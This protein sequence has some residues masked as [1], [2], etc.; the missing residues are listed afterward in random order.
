MLKANQIEVIDEAISRGLKSGGLSL[1]LGFGKTRAS[2]CLGLR[3]DMG[4]I[5]VIVSKTLMASWIQEIEKAFG[6]EFK[7]EILH[8][9]CLKK[10]YGIWEPKPE[11]KLII[12]TSEVLV[13]AYVEYNLEH[14]FCNHIIPEHFGPVVL[15]YIVPSDP[16]L[17]NMKS[18]GYIYSVKWGCLLI[19]E[20]QTFTDITRKKCRA[21]SCISS[22]YRWG[23]SGTMFDEPKTERFLG[24]YTM[25]H[26]DGPKTLPEMKIH[27]KTD[28]DGFRKY[29]IHRDTN[30]EFVKPEYVEEIVSHNLT[31]IERYVF[32]C[33]RD[34]LNS[35]NKSVKQAKTEENIDAVRT[36]N[37]YLLAMITYIRQFIISPIIPIT[38]IYCDIADFSTKTEL[39][40][41]I[42]RKFDEL[43]LEK[44]L[45]SEE[46]FISSRFLAILEKTEK[47]RGERSIVFSCFRKPL[48]LLQN[49]LDTR[50]YTTL[51]IDSDM[52]SNSRKEVLERFEKTKS[53]VLL[54]TYNTGAEGLNL[55]CASVVMLVD[56]WW[57]S[58]KIQQAIGRVFRPGQENTVYTYIFVSNTS[59]ESKMIEKNKI[60][61]EIL[62]DLEI[63]KT[64][65]KIPK[66][67]IKQIMNIINTDDN[68]IAISNMRY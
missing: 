54:L 49:I 8:K 17:R 66:L 39:S 46:S 40:G 62:K 25:L 5:L 3:Y 4:P 10:N 7:Y 19:D 13:D 48:V 45:N 35:L 57:N 37:A 63:G 47:H 22:H 1:P 20:I 34:I 29:L 23:L 38:N 21:I 26:L 9:Q 12:T 60:K 24:Y 61:A 6:N 2:I 30:E 36:F 51:T 68:K 65:K 44:W 14:L 64:T 41:I 58:A 43:N 53:C 59:M 42:A 52:S 32:E 18:S 33:S 15:E 55:Q 11:T 27:M 67:T 50:G 56:L 31:E 16:F 28:F